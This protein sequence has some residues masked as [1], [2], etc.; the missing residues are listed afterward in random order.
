VVR[1]QLLLLSVAALDPTQ[2]SNEWVPESSFLG[3]QRP[4][5][6]GDYSAGLV[7]RLSIV[8]LSCTLPYAFMPCTGFAVPLPYFRAAVSLLLLRNLVLS[9]FCIVDRGSILVIATRYG[10]DVTEIE[11]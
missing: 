11:S 10:L 1:F 8:Q 4:E 3:A 6:D 2:P 5:R 9:F 7:L